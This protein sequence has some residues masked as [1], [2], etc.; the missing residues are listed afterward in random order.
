[1][2]DK[3]VRSTDGN[4]ADDGSTWALAEADLHAPTWS[5]GDRIFVSQA[6]AQSSATTIAIASAGTLASPSQILCVDDS[7]E[8]PTALAT[9]GT[10]TTTGTAAFSLSGSVYVYGLTVFSGTG[11][12]SGPSILLTGSGQTGI[13][14]QCSFQ[15]V[16]T[17]AGNDIGFG[18]TSGGQYYKCEWRECTVKFAAVGHCININQ[19]TFEWNGGSVLSGSTAPTELFA[20]GGD[21]ARALISGV[22]LQH[23]GASTTLFQPGA[24]PSLGI[25]RDCRLPASWSGSLGTPTAPTQRVEMHN[26]DSG[27]TNYRLWVEDYAGS[28]KH[29]TTIVR[30]GGASDGTT[31]IS[32]RMATTANAE[33]P[34]VLMCSPEIVAWNDTTGSSVTATIEIVHDSM[35]AGSGSKFQDDEI[36]LE[37][38]YLGTSGYPLGSWIRDCK[39]DVLATAANQADSTETWTTTGLTTPVKQKLSVTFTPQEKGF[40]H[41]RVVMAKASKTCYVCPK[42]T[43][44]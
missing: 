22:D 2:A 8:P 39:A 15:S 14:E 25:I 40:V 33:Y 6:H 26:C 10:I 42:M 41:A 18:S 29:E 17:H 27:D 38:M 23:I 9:T 3:Y 19:T 16:C 24:R 21:G 4:N 37:V 32:W 13:F 11:S 35:G 7:A 1:M 28:V 5:A 12:S 34:V 43:V 30:T 20:F 31:T 36:W 44:A